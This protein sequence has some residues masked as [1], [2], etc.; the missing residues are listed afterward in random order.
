MGL[1]GNAIYLKWIAR[2]LDLNPRAEG[3]TGLV[4]ALVA[5]FLLLFYLDTA[6][7]LPI[8]RRYSE[9]IVTA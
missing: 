7:I 3:G 6:D 4:P 1:L 8:V 2:R 5:C 9:Y